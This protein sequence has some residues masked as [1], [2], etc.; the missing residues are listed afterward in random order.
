MTLYASS[1]TI[2]KSIGTKSDRQRKSD[3]KKCIKEKIKEKINK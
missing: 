3:D 2:A 1:D